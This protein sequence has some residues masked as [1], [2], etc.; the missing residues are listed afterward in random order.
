MNLLELKKI[1]DYTIK[2][3]HSYQHPQEIPVLI[4]LSESSIGSRAAS[5]I[6]YAGLGFDWE[7][8]QF[9]LEPTKTLVTKGNALNDKKSVKCKQF[10]GRNFYFCPRCDSK[11]AKNDSYCRDC[12]QKLR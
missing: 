9:R 12:G 6:K 10:E 3:L 1:I 7:R 2:N 11:I 5:G 8:G 4:T